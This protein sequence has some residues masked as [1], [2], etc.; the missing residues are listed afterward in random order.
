MSEMERY[1]NEALKR[2]D[3]GTREILK[4]RGY[5]KD[6]EIVQVL[7]ELVK[8]QVRDEDSRSAT[9]QTR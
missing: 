9:R 3:E 6:F 8:E 7:K 5:D 2:L 1:L 4:T